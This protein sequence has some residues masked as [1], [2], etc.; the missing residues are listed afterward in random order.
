MTYRLLATYD[1]F[2]YETLDHIG[3]GKLLSNIKKYKIHF[4]IKIRK[5]Q[6]NTKCKL[7]QAL[8]SFI[9]DKPV[10]SNMGCSFVSPGGIL[11]S[12]QVSIYSELIILN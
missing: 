5:P 7:S 4:L 10:A 1:R 6:K 8:Y 11:K 2:I 9:A 3:G 12:Q